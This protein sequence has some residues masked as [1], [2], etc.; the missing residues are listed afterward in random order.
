MCMMLIHRIQTRLLASSEVPIYQ[1][2]SDDA[3][4]GPKTTSDHM[5]SVM[6]ELVSATATLLYQCNPLSGSF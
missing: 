4:K 3:G 1:V 5:R 2:F 6:D